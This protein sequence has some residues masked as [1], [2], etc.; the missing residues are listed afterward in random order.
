MVG[1]F[2]QLWT[3]RDGGLEVDPVVVPDSLLLFH[4][5]FFL[6]SSGGGK[7]NYRESGPRE[8]NTWALLQS[9]SQVTNRKKNSPILF[10]AEQGSIF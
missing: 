3:Y 5:P 8:S 7:G 1:G 9:L 4:V 2:L 10:S 6:F